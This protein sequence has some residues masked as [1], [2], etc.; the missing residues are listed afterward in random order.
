MKSDDSFFVM[1]DDI[2][3]IVEDQE[4]I[5]LT[6]FFHL[7]KHPSRALYGLY[8]QLLV[9]ALCLDFGLYLIPVNRG[10]IL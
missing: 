8:A 5:D 2:S 3:F 7:P 1:K 10:T 9:S 6:T 4:A